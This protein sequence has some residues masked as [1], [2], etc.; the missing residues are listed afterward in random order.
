MRTS[1]GGTRSG[2][3][4]GRCEEPR[5]R[6][7]PHLC[8][9]DPFVRRGRR[10]GD[11]SLDEPARGIGGQRDRACQDGGR[12]LRP[13]QRGGYANPLRT[14][15]LAALPSAASASAAARLGRSGI[16]CGSCRNQHLSADLDALAA[17]LVDGDGGKMDIADPPIRPGISPCPAEA[18]VEH[19]ETLSGREL[20]DCCRF[21]RRPVAE[22]RRRRN[23][24][25]DRLRIMRCDHPSGERNVRKVLAIGVEVGIGGVRG[26]GKREFVSAGGRMPAPGR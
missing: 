16:D 11:D 19:L 1:P 23:F 4:G 10:V 5:N 18:V 21:L 15:R 2:A 24:P 22:Q 13:K 8:R 7:R 12:R 9:F 25:R 6:A 26:S 17:E 3:H 14:C 20:T